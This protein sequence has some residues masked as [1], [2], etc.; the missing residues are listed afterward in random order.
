[1]APPPRDFNQ[2]GTTPVGDILLQGI[3]ILSPAPLFGGR[4]HL[5]CERCLLD[6]NHAGNNPQVL[7]PGLTSSGLNDL[8][9]YFMDADNGGMMLMTVSSLL[10]RCVAVSRLT[11]EQ[12]GGA[13][14]GGDSRTLES[15]SRSTVF[16][17][18]DGIN[19]SAPLG[20][21]TSRVAFYLSRIS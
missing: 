18:L 8:Q 13:P 9:S 3:N 5:G 16:A 20:L 11:F 12:P 17:Q 7:T 10:F 14:V 21:Q 1:M 4:P 6:C 2:F 19:L 15:P